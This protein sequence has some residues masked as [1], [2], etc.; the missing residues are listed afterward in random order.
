MPTLCIWCVQYHHFPFGNLGSFAFYL[1]NAPILQFQKLK[2]LVQ[3]VKWWWITNG[4]NGTQCCLKNLWHK[5]REIWWV[6]ISYN[7]Q[8]MASGGIMYWIILE[9]NVICWLGLGMIAPN[10]IIPSLKVIMSPMHHVPN[11]EIGVQMPTK[12]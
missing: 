2:K 8:T 12:D 11:V 9:I 3:W 4:C 7:T 5:R 6:H 10:T 1:Y